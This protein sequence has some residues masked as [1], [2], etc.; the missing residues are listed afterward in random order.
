MSSPPFG[1]SE[2][3]LR[4]LPYLKQGYKRLEAFIFSPPYS[5]CTATRIFLQQRF[6]RDKGRMLDCTLETGK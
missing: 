6:L 4:T 5:N 1:S 2:Y 3:F